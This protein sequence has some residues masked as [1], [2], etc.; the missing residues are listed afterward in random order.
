MSHKQKTEAYPRPPPVPNNTSHLQAASAHSTNLN[1]GREKTRHPAAVRGDGLYKGLMAILYKDTAAKDKAIEILTDPAFIALAKSPTE[2]G[3]IIYR[4]FRG[5]LW[6]ATRTGCTLLQFILEPTYRLGPEFRALVPWHFEAV[7][8]PI[9]GQVMV[10]S[11]P[12][13]DPQAHDERASQTLELLLQTLRSE[14][15]NPSTAHKPPKNNPSECMQNLLNKTMLIKHTDGYGNKYNV[16]ITPLRYTLEDTCLPLTASVLLKN[17]ASLQKIDLFETRS[18]PNSG[19]KNQRFRIGQTSNLE[20]FMFVPGND[21]WRRVDHGSYWLFLAACWDA[22]RE[23]GIPKD[24]VRHWLGLLNDV[25][26]QAEEKDNKLHARNI[27]GKKVLISALTLM[28]AF[29][30]IRARPFLLLHESKKEL[31]KLDRR[32]VELRKLEREKEQE[33]GRALGGQGIRY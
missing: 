30:F 19:G 22:D 6:Q 24:R 1:I 8:D 4:V 18:D 3:E 25:V 21:M 14:W 31:Q 10:Y 7:G 29:D 11:G 32:I 2:G 9:L 16:E 28:E 33:K 17:G 12:E 15:K 13:R 23:H 20:S 26:R 5:I 27:Y